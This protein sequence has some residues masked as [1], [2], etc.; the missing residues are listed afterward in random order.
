MLVLTFD[1][2]TLITDVRQLFYSLYGEYTKL[3][4]QSFNIN[5]EQ[6]D[7]TL[8]QAPTSRKGYQFLFQITQK[9]EVLT[10]HHQY[11]ARLLSFKII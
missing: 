10:P 9:Y 8:I 11:K 2:L 7:A 3:Y 4:G 1:V 6:S 5:F